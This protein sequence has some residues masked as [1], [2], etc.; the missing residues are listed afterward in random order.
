MHGMAQ[1][2]HRATQ[3]LFPFPRGDLIEI[4]PPGGGRSGILQTWHDAELN[5]PSPGHTLGE[6]EPSSLDGRAR[7][8]PEVPPHGQ[9]ELEKWKI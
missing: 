7:C 6:D 5:N 1:F 4:D 3:F 9:A 2:G 8:G